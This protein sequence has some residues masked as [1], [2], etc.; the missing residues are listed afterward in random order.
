MMIIAQ[1]WKQITSWHWPYFHPREMACSHC[2]R[3]EIDERLLDTLEWQRRNGQPI[4]INSAYRCGVWNAMVGGAP[5]SQHKLG[6]A[7]D[8]ALQ[9]RTRSDVETQARGAGF[10]GIGRYRTFLHT[11]IGPR[12]VWNG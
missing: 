6:R 3:L 1:H 4:V 2:G 5:L 7:A 10:T 12:R 9:G 11:D 8:Q